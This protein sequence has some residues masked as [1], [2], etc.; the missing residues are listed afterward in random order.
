MIFLWTFVI[1]FWDVHGNTTFQFFYEFKRMD[2]KEKL[3]LSTSPSDMDYF[4]IQQRMMNSKKGEGEVIAWDITSTT[5]WYLIK[6]KWTK[7]GNKEQRSLSPAYPPSKKEPSHSLPSNGQKEKRKSWDALPVLS[8]SVFNL[9][10]NPFKRE[11]PIF[12]HSDL[13]AL[14]CGRICYEPL[15]YL[16]YSTLNIPPFNYEQ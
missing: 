12:S 2:Q 11:W 5:E 10:Q 8:R 1:F 14:K 16:L 9:T 15:S 6:G 13:N 7:Q 3:L 4:P